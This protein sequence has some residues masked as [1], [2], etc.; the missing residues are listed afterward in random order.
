VFVVIAGLLAL[1]AVAV[2]AIVHYEKPADVAT[3]MSP[4]TGV[5]VGLV[6]TYFGVRGAT[7]AQEK[8]N[9]AERIRRKPEQ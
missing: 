6:G 7:H 3:V 5:I 4:L 1:V 8:A 9:E 2:F